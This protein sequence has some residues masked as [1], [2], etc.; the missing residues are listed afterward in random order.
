MP[1]RRTGRTEMVPTTRYDESIQTESVS[2]K[3]RSQ[4]AQAAARA[5][6]RCLDGKV[7]LRVYIDRMFGFVAVLRWPRQRVVEEC[8]I[9]SNRI[10]VRKM[11]RK[12]ELGLW[13]VFV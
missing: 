11:N 1:R 2:R 12:H 3:P 8:F 4:G 6:H 10:G 5:K 13:N 7:F 9:H